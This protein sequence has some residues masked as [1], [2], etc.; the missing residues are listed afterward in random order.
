MVTFSINVQILVL[1]WG[2]DLHMC[3]VYA[4]HDPRHTGRLA[5][6]FLHRR[7]LFLVREVDVTSDAAAQSQGNPPDY[8]TGGRSMDPHHVAYSV[9]KSPVCEKTKRNQ[10]L[11][12]RW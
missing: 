11:Q 7:R 3:P 12:G 4:A 10:Q 1:M 9:L 2:L 5:E 6:P 8:P